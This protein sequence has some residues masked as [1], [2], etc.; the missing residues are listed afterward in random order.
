MKKKS[1]LLHRKSPKSDQKTSNPD[2][3]VGYKKPPVETQFKPGQSGNLKGRPK[4]SRNMKVLLKEE[5]EKPIQVQENGKMMEISKAQGIM[6]KSGMHHAMKRLG[7][8]K[9]NTKVRST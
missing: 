2:Y 5:L 7:I 3:E 8:S 9:K 6:S 1:D 4:G